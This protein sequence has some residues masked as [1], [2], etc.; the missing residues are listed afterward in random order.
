MKDVA[1][2]G[3]GLAGLNCALT[4][5]K[6]G[7]DIVVIEAADAPGG[8]VRTDQVD[9]FLLD[10]GFQV[11]LTAY[12]EAQQVL[13]Y[14]SLNLKPLTP[15]AMV[16]KNGRFHRFADP[17]REPFAALRLA[18]DP[19]VTLG[20]KLRV[21]K[22]RAQAQRGSI[23]EIFN[24]QE[25]ATRDFL[26]NFGF[27]PKMIET[28][29]EP[30]FGGVFLEKNLSTSS[31]YFE[32]LFRMFATG[33]VAVPAEGMQAIPAQMA[34][35]LAPGTIL[36]KNRVTNAASSGPGFSIAI[37]NRPAV[38][39]C[40]LVIATE[41]PAARRLQLAL[42][43]AQNHPAARRWNPT[44]AFYFAANA[45]P[46]S[47]PILLLNGEGSGAGPVN[48]A[49]VLSQVSPSYA[50]AGAHLVSASVVGGDTGRPDLEHEVRRHLGKWFGSQVE[51]WR[52]LGARFVPEALPLQQTAVWEGGQSQSGI[53]SVYLCGDFLETCSIQG[54][55]V[56]GRRAAE[57][58]LNSQKF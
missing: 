5:Q 13:D 4:L 45:A 58:V 42:N 8:R 57:A 39:A 49:V 31:R 46:V 25:S 53:E 14:N 43:P 56:S 51:R 11:L 6:A 36:L 40:R 23:P 47:E 12:P 38:A 7:L 48:N 3:A 50:P 24:R 1:I 44:I 17:F 30:F 34:D 35:R 33:A 10:R 20:D 41:E 52:S 29:F 27:S 37:E 9:G 32:F 16:W 28:F 18:V 54:A 21:A 15:G 22:L 55:L 19:I 2:I 26:R